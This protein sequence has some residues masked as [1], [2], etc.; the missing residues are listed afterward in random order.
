MRNLLL[1]L[2]VIP[3]AAFTA[4]LGC[5]SGPAAS[6]AI[7]Y[8]STTQLAEGAE[9]TLLAENATVTVRRSESDQLKIDTTLSDA[10]GVQYFVLPESEAPVTKIVINAT[11]R[12]DASPSTRS[13]ITL[14]IP[15][16][17]FLRIDD[18]NGSLDVEG[19][20]I[21]E[22][23]LITTE[24]A[25]KL[26]TSTGNF[27]LNTTNADLEI[28]GSEGTFWTQTTNGQIKFDGT[29][30]NDR[31]S[32]FV[33]KNGNVDILLQGEPDLSMAV[34]AVGGQFSVPDGEYVREDRGFTYLRYGVGTGFIE[35]DVQNGNVNINLAKGF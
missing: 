14:H 28:L 1:I 23:N 30:T 2:T 34:K 9:V 35:F 3:T 21:V 33:N 7:T 6:G 12:P 27:T 32:R 24:A 25:V 19:V 26:R 15:D 18:Q 13:E 31:Q 20:K 5:N 22:S 4:A 8:Q 11:L 29:I 10:S 16:G 17:M